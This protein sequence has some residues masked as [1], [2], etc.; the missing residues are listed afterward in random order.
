MYTSTNAM[1]GTS[2]KQKY[3]WVF[4][5]ALFTS[6]LYLSKAKSYQ[7]KALLRTYSKSSSYI[8]QTSFTILFHI[9]S[10]IKF[11]KKIIT[12]FIIGVY[13]WPGRRWRTFGLVSY[14]LYCNHADFHFSNSCRTSSL[15]SN[16]SAGHKIH[17]MRAWRQFKLRQQASLKITP[18][19]AETKH[20]TKV[21]F[22]SK[23]VKSQ[24]SAVLIFCNGT[25]PVRSGM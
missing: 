13:G 14:F 5:Q 1:E 11:A 3:K 24:H 18:R 12:Y 2:H 19:C 23:I 21:L 7:K 15:F 25:V 22:I 9:K 6:S 17:S 4:L 16:S 8:L 20:I 10:C